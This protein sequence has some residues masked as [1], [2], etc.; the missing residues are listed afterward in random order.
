MSDI[1]TLEMPK[2]G[3]SMEEGSLAQWYIQEG[4]SFTKGQE[5]CEIETSKIVNVLEAPFGGTLRRVLARQGDTLQVGAV[6]ALVAEAAISDV[7]L[8]A[9]TASLATAEPAAPVAPPPAPP[10]AAPTAGKTLPTAPSPSAQ[11]AAAG[12]QTEVPVGLQGSTD[13]TQV[14]AT[15]H[16]LRLAARLGVDLGKVRGSGRGERISVAD[17]ESAILA[18]GGRI[19]SPTPPSRSGK[20]PRSHA[21]DSQVSATPLAR[22]LAGKLGI[23]LHDCRSSGSHGRVSREDVQAAAL[24]LDGQPQTAT[25]P[26]AAPAAFENLPLSGMRR[27]IATRL[28]ASKQHSPHFRLIAELD[29]ERL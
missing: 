12:G 10:V 18:A 15:P 22:R 24:L 8:D 5:I 28:Q 14:N 16:A 23:N 13:A 9:F 21:D 27:A 19:A 20:A 11:P 2:W 1:K 29:L 26:N 17:L 6:L 25:A 4:D 7:E 3:L